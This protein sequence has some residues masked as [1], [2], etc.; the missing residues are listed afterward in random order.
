ME[1]DITK[2]ES[3]VALFDILGFSNLLKNNELDKV[4]NTYIKA[5]KDF[6]DNV[7]H[8]NSLLQKDAVTFHIFSDT[9]LMY[10]SEVNGTSFLALLAACDFLFLA[11]IENELPIRG[12]TAVGELIVSHGI[13][14]G[15]PIVE[16]YENEKKQ[17]WIGCWITD[18]C[19]AIINRDK[20]LT[21]KDIVEYE[22]PLKDGEVKKRYAFNWVKSLPRKI[23]HEKKKRDF[24]TDE[25]KEEIK[26]LREMPSDWKVK[27]MHDNTIKF[28]DFVL[29]P[30]FIKIYK[31]SSA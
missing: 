1:K 28:I 19:M 10:T 23:M 26:F 18:D 8:I 21:G 11:A 3:F 13:E 14:I 25:I 24:T 9:F 29:S 27:R 15:K 31:S 16:A 30:E 6:E 20:H 22:I 12:A 4:A 2:K 5:K 17:D 7:S